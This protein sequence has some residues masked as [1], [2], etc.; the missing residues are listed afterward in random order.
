MHSHVFSDY[1]S[2][3]NFGFT[4]LH[5]C[6]DDILRVTHHPGR[7]SS[8]AAAQEFSCGGL[9]RNFLLS[10][11]NLSFEESEGGKEYC[12]RGHLSAQNGEHTLVEAHPAVLVDDL[13]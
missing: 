9:N 6:F 3:G 7:N 13:V 4:K 11:S 1:L 5:F 2:H 8:E 12:P 10:F